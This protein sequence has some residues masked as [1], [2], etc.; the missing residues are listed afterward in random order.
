MSEV[1]DKTKCISWDFTN[2]GT[3]SVGTQTYY[4]PGGINTPIGKLI[5][6]LSYNPIIVPTI[7]NLNMTPG[8]YPTYSYYD[9]SNIFHVIGQKSVPTYRYKGVD[10]ANNPVYYEID[11]RFLKLLYNKNNTVFKNGSV[12][13]LLGANDMFEYL[14][15]LPTGQFGNYS[16]VRASDA[17]MTIDKNT[18][19]GSIEPDY[20]FYNGV[21]TYLDDSVIV[22]NRATGL[23]HDYLFTVNLTKNIWPV[24]GYPKDD[25][26]ALN[27]NVTMEAISTLQNVRPN[28]INTIQ[29]PIYSAFGWNDN[30]QTP[31]EAGGQPIQ[32]NIEI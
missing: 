4:M 6:I 24:N 31:I 17:Y 1:L 5:R 29:P 25:I 13:S 16:G 2:T 3:Y 7:N 8:G 23:G 27:A 19:Y 18:D 12:S 9:S 21:T 28:G 30:T 32:N 15:S 20:R 10:S 26:F 14:M 22:T 11:T